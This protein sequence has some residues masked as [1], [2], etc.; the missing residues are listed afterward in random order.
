MPP[1]PETAGRSRFGG[2]LKLLL[3]ALQ[4]L[5]PARVR[6]APA[7]DGAIPVDISE[8]ELSAGSPADGG[9]DTTTQTTPDAGSTPVAE[10]QVAKSG[11]LRGLLT[12]AL[13]ALTV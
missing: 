7:D 3:A 1:E 10:P 8:P 5:S 4:V 9:S 6:A 2:L 13:A 11:G 12:G